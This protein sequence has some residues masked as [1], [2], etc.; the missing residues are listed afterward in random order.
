MVVPAR[1]QKSARKRWVISQPSPEA[2]KLA[3][4]LKVSSLL[5]QVLINRGLADQNLCR[6]FLTPKLTD[7]IDPM[8]MPGMASALT[9]IRRAIAQKEKITIYG[10][11]DVD[12]ITATSILWQC[13][14][15]LDAQ[16]DY[17]I[18]HRV[19]EGYG[20]NSEAIDQIAAADTKLII[21]V[22]CGITAVEPVAKAMQ[23]GMDVVITDHHQ[24]SSNLPNA[25]AIVHP[26]LESTYANPSSAGAMVAFK[27]AW[28]LVNEFKTTSRAEGPLRDFLINATT[29]ASLGTVADVVEL[30]GENRIITS[31]GLKALPDCPLTG[32]KALLDCAGLTGQSLD[33]YHIGFVL[34]PMLNAAGRMGHARLAVE[35]LTSDNQLRSVHI[36]EYLKAQNKQRQQ[37]EKEILKHACEMV[38]HAG[39]DHPDRKSIVLAAENWHIGVI[40]IVASRLVEKFCRPT[41]LLNSSTATT[42]GSARSIPGFDIL[43]G[44][45]SC[46][47]HCVSFGGH[48]MAA[49]VAIAKEKLPEFA[50]AFEQ[51]AVENICDTDTESKLNIDALSGVGHFKNDMVSQLEILGPFGQGNP[52]P[53]FASKA[54][55]LIAS[56]RRVGAKGEHIQLS[57]SDSSG[58]VRCIGFN[59]GHL[60]KKLLEQEFFNIAY[61]PQLNTYNGSTSV[62][63]VLEDVNF[64]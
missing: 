36:A 16:V 22:D 45:R 26:L 13:L 61:Q 21:T 42:H 28:A 52:K 60:E 43:A 41:I 32:I 29:L 37:H 40:G 50:A 25:C 18:P 31:Y 44:I 27:L 7:L 64:D 49:G 17:Y 9:R 4:S 47:E 62:Q 1:M 3:Q 15:L 59:M 53:I 20:L 5:A 54:V 30:M 6:S 19:D 23:M 14:R 63:L 34:A 12:G 39:L 33:S 51:Y 2:P 10:D 8:L 46:A 48:K 57:I 56:P 11:Y 55:K 35:L 38:S 58:A 24:Y